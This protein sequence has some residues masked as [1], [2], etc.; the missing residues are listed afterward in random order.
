MARY[1]INEDTLRVHD[2]E[3][4]GPISLRQEVERL[5]ELEQLKAEYSPTKMTVAI[6]QA[7]E[8]GYNAGRGLKV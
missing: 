6:N 3:T 4:G 5:N 2:N 8:A 7:Y 1:E